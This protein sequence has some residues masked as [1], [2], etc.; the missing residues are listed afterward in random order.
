MVFIDVCMQSLN[1]GPLIFVE[2][3]TNRSPL[4]HDDRSDRRST[5]GY[6]FNLGS[7]AISWSSKK[8][9]AVAL[10]TCEA[11]YMAMTQ[12]AKEAIWLRKLFRELKSSDSDSLP[13]TIYPDNQGAIALAKN[14]EF[15]SRTKHIDIQYHF[16]RECIDRGQIKLEYIPTNDQVADG[17][18]KALPP[19]KFLKF[20]DGLGICGSQSN[21]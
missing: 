20:R 7:G 19:T 16:V 9:T 14:P 1:C 10:S 11:E 3:F 17:L 12:S 8:Q 2:I 4:I 13:T 18:T 5:G 21:D 6:V 15:H